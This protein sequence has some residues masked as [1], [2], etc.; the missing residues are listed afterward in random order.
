VIMAHTR[1]VV[2]S[3]VI[4]KRLIYL[5]RVRDRQVRRA[6]AFDKKSFAIAYRPILTS[7]DLIGYTVVTH[8][9]YKPRV[10]RIISYDQGVYS[11]A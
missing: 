9:A 1:P 5:S 11:T 7:R 3:M 2:L 6:S 10:Y 4:H 8:H